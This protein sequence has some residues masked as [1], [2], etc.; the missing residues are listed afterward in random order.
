MLDRNLLRQSLYQ[1]RQQLSL[2]DQQNYTG[3]IITHCL[4]SSFFL[5]SESVAC[6]LAVRHEV[7]CDKLIRMIF[8]EDKKCYLPVVHEREAGKMH[9][10]RYFAKEKLEKNRYGILE[11]HF[12]NELEISPEKLDLIVLP[13][14]GFNRQ[15]ARLGSGGGYYDRALATLSAKRPTLVG[16]AYS[17][18]EVPELIAEPWDVKLDLIITEKEII[19]SQN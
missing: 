3:Q 8:K 15:G 2:Q 6:Y 19:N 18:Q 10:I 7:S 1:K 12:S 11:P 17:L 13:V 16:L 5:K 9:F 14:V 4:Q